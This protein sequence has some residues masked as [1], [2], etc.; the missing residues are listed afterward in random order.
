[1]ERQYGPSNRRKLTNKQR[2]MRKLFNSDSENDEIKT[3]ETIKNV[4]KAKQAFDRQLEVNLSN[5]TDDENDDV[6]EIEINSDEFVTP[7]KL[8]TLAHTPL[9]ISPLQNTPVRTVHLNEHVPVV[10]ITHTF[11]E[12]STCTVKSNVKKAV[13]FALPAIHT[14]NAHIKPTHNQA[15]SA[16]RFAS[17]FSSC[18]R[19]PPSEQAHTQSSTLAP[20]CE[21][22]HNDDKR[23]HPYKRTP[24]TRTL[25]QAPIHSHT[26]SLAQSQ[27]THNARLLNS[28]TRTITHLDSSHTHSHSHPHA[29]NSATITKTSIQ[30]KQTVSAVQ[31]ITQTERQAAADKPSEAPISKTIV[32]K[33]KYVPNGIKLSIAVDTNKKLSKNARKKITRQLI[34]EF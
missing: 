6:L 1:M 34:S 19:M 11:K 24:L 4:N 23:I 14:N 7:T 21:K 9:L 17:A 33:N 10:T 30:A 18:K 25:T 20:S 28:I 26:Q 22:P 16:K 13:R 32:L 2:L 8:S 31:P 15:F 12:P 3:S 5:L 29:F 27:S